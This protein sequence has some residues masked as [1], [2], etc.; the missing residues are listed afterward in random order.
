MP[1]QYTRVPLADRF[2]R[3]F[4]QAGDCWEWRRN[5]TKQGYGQIRRGGKGDGNVYAHRLAWELAAGAPIPPGMDV[6]HT[7]D[8]RRCVRND[9]PG[10][11]IIRGIAR[12]RYGHL[13]LG[14]NADNVQDAVDKGRNVV[15][16]LRILRPRWRGEN[17]GNAKLSAQ[18]VAT[19]K[20]VCQ[21]GRIRRAVIARHYGVSPALITMIANGYR[22]TETPRLAQH[23]A[24]EKGDTR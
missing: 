8:N 21:R 11:Y 19:I 4:N 23:L 13:W 16:H 15:E 6:C 14:T 12:P 3:H 7:C 18:Q 24:Q 2:L 10:I 9:T 1:R 20:A 22:W 17:H 5:L